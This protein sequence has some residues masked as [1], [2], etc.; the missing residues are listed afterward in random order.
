MKSGPILFMLV[1]CGLV[2]WFY[3]DIAAISSDEPDADRPVINAGAPPRPPAAEQLDVIQQQWLA[4][5][6]VLQRQPDGHFYAD[7]TAGVTPLH[8]MVDTGASVVALTAEDARALGLRW[9]EEDV[10]PI[11]HGA[12]GEVSGINTTI[13]RLQLGEI[14]A[15]DVRAVVIPE[16]LMTSLLGQSFLSQIRRVEIVDDKMV[17]GG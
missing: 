13:K 9:D 8:M 6:T 11:G 2:G 12:S 7:L 3:T 10:V 15:Y 5:E 1:A 17:L 14:E 4:G 16:G